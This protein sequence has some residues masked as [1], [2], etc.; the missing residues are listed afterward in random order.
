MQLS[1]IEGWGKEAHDAEK[2]KRKK[3]DANSCTRVN[4]IHSPCI[5]RGH[6]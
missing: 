2:D 6:S 1:Y 4:V 3:L 5:G